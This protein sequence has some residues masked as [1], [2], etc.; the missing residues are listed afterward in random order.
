[1][2]TKFKLDI[3][4]ISDK[5]KMMRNNFIDDQLDSIKSNLPT[6]EE[7]QKITNIFI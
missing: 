2:Q 7:I 6:D 4:E 5:I 3:N 1:M